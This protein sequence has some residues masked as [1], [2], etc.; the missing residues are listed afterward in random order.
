MVDH[1]TFICLEGLDGC[2][3]TTQAKLLARRL[4]TKYEAIYTA[5]PSRG[6]IGKFIKKRYL[7]AS[8]RGSTVVEALLFAADRV[9]HLKNEV[10]PALERGKIVVSD[11]YV[12]SSLAYQGAAGIDLEWIESVNKHAF[13]PDLA[14]F[15]DVDPKTVVGRLKQKKSVMENLETQ[16]KV[17]QIY[18]KYVET[19]ALVR[20]DGNKSKREVAKAIWQAV[21]DHLHRTR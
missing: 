18:S 9:E 16:L 21:S 10:A 17:Q 11:R 20:I 5:E 2:G 6:Q 1:G 12:F 7:H 8:T 4:K 13:R 19:G 3:K 14:L 15:I